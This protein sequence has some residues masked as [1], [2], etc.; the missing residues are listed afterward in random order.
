ME[1]TMSKLLIALLAGMI[2]ST[3]GTKT[4]AQSNPIFVQLGRAKGVLYKA[5]AGPEPRTGIIVMHRESNYLNHVACGEFARRGFMVLC[6]NSRFENSEASVKWE[7]IPLD[8]AA[9][10]TI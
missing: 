10:S 1:T 6:M 7:L 8:V 9:A 4:Q 2:A 5:D 3:A